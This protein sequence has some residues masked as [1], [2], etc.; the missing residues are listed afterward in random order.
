MR[1]KLLSPDEILIGYDAV[2]QL[3]PYNP[4]MTLWR[5]W[6]FAAYQHY[7]LP[8]PLLDIGCGDGHF[9][10]LVWPQV[11]DAVGVDMNAG[12]VNAARQSG[13]YREVYAA[14]A[15]QLPIQ[16]NSFASAF[17]N[18]SLEHMDHLPEVLAS[19]SRSVRAGSPFLLSVVT[20]K[21]L[22]WAALPLLMDALGR[23]EHAQRLRAEHSAY[24]HLVNPLPVESWVEHL[25]AAGFKV[26][27][28]IPI[29]P[30]VTSRVFLFLDNLWHVSRLDKE[31]GEWLMPF[32]ET[33]SDFPA[34]FRDVFAGI[35]RMERDWSTSSGAVFCVRRK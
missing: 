10:R 16:P 34:A 35:L 8:E 5:A 22:E 20:D 1:Q 6:E 18:C 19:I 4:P 25:E 3:Y 9:L 21:F 23:P 13:V 17:A 24:H 26:E 29:L 11:T 7:Q 30:E 14:P 32:F 15:H 31:L 27:E 12:V 2:S 28:H 33:L